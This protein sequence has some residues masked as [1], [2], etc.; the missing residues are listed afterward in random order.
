M[1]RMRFPA[2]PAVLLTSLLA[3]AACSGGGGH[4]AAGGS[5]SASPPTATAQSDESSAASTSA[6]PATQV[7][8]Q[9]LTD[10]AVDA[11]SQPPSEWKL[12][13]REHIAGTSVQNGGTCLDSSTF[14]TSLAGTRIEYVRNPQPDGTGHGQYEVSIRATATPAE[15]AAQLQALSQLSTDCADALGRND[16]PGQVT[17]STTAPRPLALSQQSAS[18]RTIAHFQTP[19]RQFT[20]YADLVYLSSGRL[21][22]VVG[23]FDCCQPIEDSF[24][25][26][27]LTEVAADLQNL[28][29][30]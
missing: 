7:D 1:A 5:N 29:S 19:T 10:R 25:T 9:A 2:V 18:Y 30:E 21:R 27:V 11:L 23:F 8:P 3:A 14:A 16:V 20:Y 24:Q 15:A 22:A 28:S 12:L 4:V 6:P 13:S 26:T 17:D